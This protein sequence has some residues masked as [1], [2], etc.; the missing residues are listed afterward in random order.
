VQHG[1]I[2]EAYIQSSCC[3]NSA[4]AL[5]LPQKLAILPSTKGPVSVLNVGLTVFNTNAVFQPIASIAVHTTL[6]SLSVK[7]TR[8]RRSQI[9]Q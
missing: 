1:C 5:P 6:F 7:E 8:L 9:L 4:N 2:I 3:P